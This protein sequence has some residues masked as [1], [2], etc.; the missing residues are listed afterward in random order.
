MPAAV[1]PRVRL[2]GC[3]VGELDLSEAAGCELTVTDSR[4]DRLV[5][6]HAHL[7]AADLRGASPTE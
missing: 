2:D 5:L 3:R 1:R 4:I 7:T 6:T